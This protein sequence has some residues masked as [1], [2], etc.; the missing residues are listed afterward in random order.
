MPPSASPLERCPAPMPSGRELNRI[1]VLIPTG[2]HIYRTASYGMIVDFED[3]VARASDADVVPV[4]L[5]SRRAQ[6][7]ALLR[8]RCEALLSAGVDASGAPQ[9][10]ISPP[11][12]SYDVCLLVAMG[13]DWLPGLIYL[14]DLKRSCAR[15]AVYLFDSWLSDL[16]RIAKLRRALSFVDDLFVSFRHTLEPYA[17]RL[18]CRVHYLPQAI[19]PRWFHPQRGERPI[20]VL[21]V[22]RRL[23]EA[24]RHL[25][26][27]SR[28]RDLF[29]HYQTHVAPG[30]GTPQAIDLLENQELLGRLCQSSRVH[31][32]WSVDRTNPARAGEGGAITARWFESAA[33]GAAVIGSAPRTDQFT[34]LFP[35]QGFVR[36]LDQTG[37]A[38][39][40]AILDEALTDSR[41]GERLALADHVRRVHTWGVRWRQIVEVCD[42]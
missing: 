19:D 12:S 28:Q 23:P 29:Y 5:R 21:S 30:S 40:E 14:R 7:K 11:R 33:C 4:P 39:T 25:L 35:Y 6:A 31:V 32:N 27:L 37:R 26:E 38:A 8:G 13:V 22:G 41:E 2:R 20:D 18:P 42:L 3:A 36:E 9:R 10:A 34:R 17:E 16:P 15:V 1:R 24:H